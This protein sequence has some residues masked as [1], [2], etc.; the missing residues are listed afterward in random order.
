MQS[1]ADTL[2]VGDHCPSMG[3]GVQAASDPAAD[4]YVPVGHGAQGPPAGPK[5]PAA[6]KVQLPVEKL[7]AG[8]ERVGGHGVQVS[9]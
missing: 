5:K 1:S 7:P 2:P 4:L 6:H 3:H 8:A 9:E